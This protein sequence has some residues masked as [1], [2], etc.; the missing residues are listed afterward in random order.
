MCI[1]LVESSKKTAYGKSRDVNNWVNVTDSSSTAQ[2]PDTPLRKLL[3]SA[4]LQQVIVICMLQL[5]VL[6]FAHA[7]GACILC[8]CP[9]GVHE[10]NASGNS[11]VY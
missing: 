3:C 6:Q 7:C 9:L 2:L 11:R 5:Q 10:P 4:I 1:M 8:V